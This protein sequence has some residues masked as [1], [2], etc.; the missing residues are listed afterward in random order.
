MKRSSSQLKALARSSLSGQWGLPI[1]ASVLASL[2]VLIPGMLIAGLLDPYST[3]SIITCQILIYVVSILVSLL[4]IGYTRLVLNM[5]RRQPYSLKDLIYPYTAHP[6]RFLAV[7]LILVTVGAVL[8]LP[9]TIL[10]Y[11][12]TD[13]TSS[14]VMNMTGLLVES[15]VS[16]ILSL[17]FGLANYLLLDNENM[18]AAQ[19]LRESCRLMK[20][21]KGRYL[22]ITFSF[23]PLALASIFTCYIGLLWLNP[24]ISVTMSYF[25]MDVTGELDAPR[26]HHQQGSEAPRVEDYY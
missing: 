12:Q 23:I 18:T 17:F 9:F 4:Q 14:M 5:N 8:S 20:G 11:Q 19:A 1:G 21:N 3:V 25:Y 6:D 24:Y 13:L 22:Y 16:I 2:G 10:S 26:P 15:L 7:N